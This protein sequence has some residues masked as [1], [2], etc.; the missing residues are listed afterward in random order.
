MQRILVWLL[1]YRNIGAPRIRVNINFRVVLSLEMHKQRP[2]DTQ[3][4]FLLPRS[5]TDS[6][7]DKGDIW[8]TFKQSSQE[9][10]ASIPGP[11]L[12]K[13]PIREGIH[14]DQELQRI[15]L[16]TVKQNL[17]YA[18]KTKQRAL[19]NPA[20]LRAAMDVD[21]R[22]EILERARDY[23][24]P[25]EINHHP[26]LELWIR[27]YMDYCARSPWLS[28]REKYKFDFA[29]SV[30]EQVDLETQSDAEIIAI[31]TKEGQKVNFIQTHGRR[32]VAI[33]DEAVISLIRKLDAEEELTDKDITNSP[34]SATLLSSWLGT[35][36]S[37]R[38][39]PYANTEILKPLDFIFPQKVPKQGAKA[40]QTSQELMYEISSL[41]ENSIEQ[42]IPVLIEKLDLIS[43][44][45]RLWPWVVQDFL[46]YF[47]RCKMDPG[48][49]YWWVNQ[50]ASFEYEKA[51]N[52]VFAAIDTIHHHKA[53]QDLREVD[54]LLHY[55]NGRLMAHSVVTR[56][57]V[58]AIYPVQGVDEE[59]KG[60]MVQTKYHLLKEPIPLEEIQKKVKQFKGFLPDKQSPFN[61]ELGINHG[62]LFS[63]T[64]E[65]FHLLLDEPNYWVF[66]GNPSQYDIA[67]SLRN[68]QLATWM[69]KAHKSAIRI[70]DKVILWVSGSG[71][72]CF[73]LA[74]VA[75]EV[76]HGKM[77]LKN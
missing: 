34:V 23:T 41:M 67:G 45:D 29:R 76:Y 53:I 6:F 7:F 52:F 64:E 11:V 9:K 40:F 73:A 36:V 54:R 48:P 46:Y 10:Q 20:I 32:G 72:G 27:E 17:T 68:G 35:L 31:C 55:V 77:N 18:R 51:G 60:W 4:V 39:F 33:I 24:P 47:L 16:E 70:G 56:E 15:W 14:N 71:G 42:F 25:P 2:E 1:R 19:H 30:Q 3:V 50:D 49:Q 44:D 57:F 5:A 66:Q 61:R 65:L 12:M 38:F 69:V 58:E 13:F 21:Y 74:T 26:A 37:D 62:Y 28:F 75:S 59:K 22:E 43:W 63:A 8:F